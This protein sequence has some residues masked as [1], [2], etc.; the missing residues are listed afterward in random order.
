MT[1]DSTPHRRVA[2]RVRHRRRQR[3]RR[4]RE[5]EGRLA[6]RRRD[7][8]HD[9]EERRRRRCS[10]LALALPVCMA[11]PTVG[12]RPAR[13][14]TR[15]AVARARRGRVHRRQRARSCSSSRGSRA[16][17]RRRPR[18]ST[19]RSSSGSRCSPCRSSASGSGRR[20]SP[21]SRSSS[22]GRPGSSGELGTVAFGAGEAMIL[23]ATLLWAVE[24]IL[25]KRAPRRARPADARRCAHGARHGRARRLARASRAASATCSRS[26]PTSGS[27]RSLTGLLLTAYVATWYAALARAQAVDVTAVLVFGAVVTAVL[28]RVADGAAVDPVGVGTRHRRCGA[29]RARPR[30]APFRDRRVTT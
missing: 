29:R 14:R 8:L 18:S 17:P 1:L 2:H 30:C 11:R 7:R 15:R 22:P 10:S 21:R 16:R 4:L 3:R 13:P 5:L 28:A 24:V 25:V 6:L 23:A 27:G 26:A 12:M 19:R 9:G 20:T